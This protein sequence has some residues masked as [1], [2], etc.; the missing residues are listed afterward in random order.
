MALVSAHSPYFLPLP[1]GRK[2]NQPLEIRP[3]IQDRGG[4]HCCSESA[5]RAAEQESKVQCTS[6]TPLENSP[7]TVQW[8]HYRARVSETN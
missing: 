2:Y 1:S 4:N 3:F 7:Q 6:H 5:I 8:C